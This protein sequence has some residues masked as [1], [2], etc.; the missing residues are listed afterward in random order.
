MEIFEGAGV[1]VVPGGPPAGLVVGQLGSQSPVGAEVVAE[2]GQMGDQRDLVAADGNQQPL[3]VGVGVDVVGEPLGRI[4]KRVLRMS[5]V[6]QGLR[7]R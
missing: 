5:G 1:D 3:A 4:D 6:V 7:R 2:R